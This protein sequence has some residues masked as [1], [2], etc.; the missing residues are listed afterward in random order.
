MSTLW[1]AVSGL[2][3][4]LALFLYGMGAMTEALED[5]AGARL[6]SALAAATGT[7]L[8]G[9]LAGAAATA[10]LQSSSAVTVALLGFVGAGLMDLSQAI[11][12]IFGANV[13]TTVTAQLL[14]L[15]LD[16]LVYPILFAS[17]AARSLAKRSRGKALAGAAFSFALLLEGIRIISRAAEPLLAGPRFAGLMALA[18]ERPLPGL[19]L[20]ASM[21]VLAQSSSATVALLQRLAACPGPDGVS[22]PLGLPGAIPILLGC[23]IGTTVTGLLAAAGGSK[24]AKRAALAHLIFNLTGAAV[25]L[26]LTPVLARLTA[27]LSPAGPPAAVI[28]RQIA[29]AH[30]L[31]NLACALAWLPLTGPMARLVTWLVPDEKRSHRSRHNMSP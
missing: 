26:P 24:D 17:F 12:V 18:A 20:G 15:D 1:P 11:P 7:P 25:F 3:G 29:N 10:V 14:A 13:G 30:T 31:F 16:G 8:T 27:A 22:S 19:A 5:A 21:T 23:N 9:T 6:R 2:L 28:A 4:G